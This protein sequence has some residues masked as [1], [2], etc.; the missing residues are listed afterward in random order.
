M[1]TAICTAILIPALLVPPLCGQTR[2]QE[3]ARALVRRALEDTAGYHLLRELT[4]LGH[5]L[6]GSP[7]A[8]RAVRWAERTMTSLGL[9]NV[10]LQE[11]PVP[12]W[13]R[14]E[15]ET[16]CIL[17][18]RGGSG[19]PLAVAALGTSVGTAPG[20]ISAEVLEVQ[21]FEELEARGAEA[22]G[23]IIFFNR[24]M[25]PGTITTFAAYGGAVGQRVQGAVKAAE[26]GGVAAL[27]R[28]VTTKYDNVPHTGTMSYRDGVPKVP[29]A[30]IGLIDADR[31]SAALH[32]DPH[33]RV[34]LSLSCRNYPDTTSYT[35]FGQI[36]GWEYPREIIVIGG[37]FDSWD[38][39]VGAH[40]DGAGCIQALEV[41]TLFQRLG[42]RP[43]RTVR[44][45][46]FMN[47]EM[48]LS[49]ADVYGRWT[50]SNGEDHIAGIEADRGA[51]TPRGFYV[52]ASPERLEKIQSWLPLLQEACIDWVKKGG[53]GG[54]VARI[55]EPE[56]LVGY[57]PDVQ[58]YFDFHHSA[59][60]VFAE[61]HP[62]EM[63]LGSAAMAILVYLLAE[64]G[65]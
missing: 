60:D 11:C 38:K 29:A 27:V 59:N 50:A 4:A 45:V 48:G 24:P 55:H 53:S 30:A 31:L 39:G 62:R 25:D 13:E 52:T 22:A 40:D 47:E 57:V 63:E 34:R 5:R 42:I 49:G 3:L 51:L 56:A 26:A 28:S 54:D 17:D 8:A 33:L 7:G 6:P 12:R 14:G 15:R 9:D 61:I 19:E 58:R 37:H 2:D 32:D 1:R 43:K 20:G 46:F 10:T 21:S 16:A 41:L 35:V 18:E 23:K 44:A 65:L 64:Y 36:T